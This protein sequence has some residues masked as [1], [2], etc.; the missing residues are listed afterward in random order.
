MRGIR[1][2]AM[3]QEE[4]I[5]PTYPSAYPKK[6]S[7]KQSSL[8][9]I[10]EFNPSPAEIRRDEFYDSYEKQIDGQITLSLTIKNADLSDVKTNFDNNAY[11]WGSINT[12]AT[13]I[14]YDR[15]KELLNK[16]YESQY[17]TSFQVEQGFDEIE[18]TVTLIPIDKKN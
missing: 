14:A 15:I 12:Q 3:S 9:D 5:T 13:E 6:Y 18:V 11:D 4:E 10:D 8:Y 1:E 2:A 7:S 16:E 17:K